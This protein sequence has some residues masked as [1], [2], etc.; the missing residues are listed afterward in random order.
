MFLLAMILGCSSTTPAPTSPPDGEDPSEPRSGGERFDLVCGGKV[1]A[2]FDGSGD[3]P[4]G[5][6]LPDLVG[7]AANGVE[8]RRGPGAEGL[9]C[10]SAGLLML[11]R[12]VWNV[13]PSDGLKGTVAVTPETLSFAYLR[14]DPLLATCE[15]KPDHEVSEG[16][17][18][19]GEFVQGCAGTVGWSPISKEI[20]VRLYDFGTGPTELR[21]GDAETTCGWVAVAEKGERACVYTEVEGSSSAIFP[22]GL[23]PHHLPDY[24]AATVDFETTDKEWDVVPDGFCSDLIGKK[25]VKELVRADAT[26]PAKPQSVPSSPSGSGVVGEMLEDGKVVLTHWTQHQ[27]TA[28]DGAAGDTRK[29]AFCRRHDVPKTPLTGT[30]KDVLAGDVENSQEYKDFRD[31]TCEGQGV[32]HLLDL[33]YSVL[34]E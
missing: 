32:V 25:G 2:S 5:C 24:T 23:H 31:K 16:E 13:D 1:C 9:D 34:S 19:Y 15:A 18:T 27:S 20:E 21:C 33:S 29:V 4:A 7:L 8:V 14:G 26:A 17:Q 12:P 22:A 28:P 11:R 30:L 6:A 3:Q 10:G